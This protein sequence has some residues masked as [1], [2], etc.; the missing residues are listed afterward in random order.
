MTKL[1]SIGQVA[2]LKDV[3]IQALRYY[4]TIG[5]FQPAIVNPKTN[6]RYYHPKQLMFL[7]IIKC[8]RDTDFLLEELGQNLYDCSNGV[9]SILEKGQADLDQKIQG[10]KQQKKKLDDVRQWFLL[11]KA[12]SQCKKGVFY[13][14]QVPSHLQYH[15][16]AENLSVQGDQP[17]FE[18]RVKGSSKVTDH[19]YY[20]GLLDIQKV[21]FLNQLHYRSIY[22]IEGDQGESKDKVWINREPEGPYLGICFRRSSEA[23]LENYNKICQAILKNPQKLDSVICESSVPEDL[24]NLD[25]ASWLTELR[26]RILSPIKIQDL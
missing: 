20:G 3:S 1:Y 23:Y 19:K 11:Y 6:Y 13:Q 16:N 10:F 21:K 7:D 26:V 17:Y 14:R 5:L 8:L 18:L 25:V 24:L 9:F 2:K 15:K 22:Q 12:L 4:D